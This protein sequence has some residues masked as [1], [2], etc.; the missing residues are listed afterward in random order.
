MAGITRGTG[1]AY[2][3][4]FAN[5]SI[6][7]SSLS[8]RNGMASTRGN[9]NGIEINAIGGT[10]NGLMPFYYSSRCYTFQ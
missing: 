5:R 4:G 6:V 8:F 10:Y 1:I 7:Y 3:T 9:R 2:S